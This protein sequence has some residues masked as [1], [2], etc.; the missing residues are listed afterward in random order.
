M[1]FKKKMAAVLSRKE[2]QVLQDFGILVSVYFTNYTC[3][4]N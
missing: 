1:T 3:I 4:F 2:F